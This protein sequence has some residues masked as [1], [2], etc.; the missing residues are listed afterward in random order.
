MKITFSLLLLILLSLNSYSQT[1]LKNTIGLSGGFTLFGTG[2]IKGYHFT[3][4]YERQLT[5]RIAFQSQLSFASAQKQSSAQDFGVANNPYTIS[6]LQSS[7]QKLNV[8]FL[9]GIFKRESHF[10]GINASVGSVRATQFRYGGFRINPMKNPPV[11]LE[12]IPDP[13]YFRRSLSMGFSGGLEYRYSISKHFKLGMEAAYQQYYRDT[14]A[15]VNFG[16]YYSF[17][18]F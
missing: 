3:P 11:G 17:H 13:P 2:D 9:V 10:W 6:F 18:R 15:R 7:S 5:N 16:A 1:E 12:Y 14:E 4:K 8:G